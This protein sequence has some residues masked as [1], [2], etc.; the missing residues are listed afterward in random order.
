MPAAAATPARALLPPD[1][2]FLTLVLPLPF[3]KGDPTSVGPP[4]CLLLDRA[5]AL[6]R[7]KDAQTAYFFF[8]AVTFGQGAL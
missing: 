8:L 5:Y 3:T 1:L 6:A 7:A 4:L 2:S